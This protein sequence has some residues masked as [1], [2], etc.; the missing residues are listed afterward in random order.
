M[1]SIGMD[2]IPVKAA[3]PLIASGLQSVG[4]VICLV[5]VT[6][7]AKHL[8]YFAGKAFATNSTDLEQEIVERITAFK[9]GGIS[10][11]AFAEFLLGLSNQDISPEIEQQILAALGKSDDQIENT[12]AESIH[13]RNT[14]IA[15]NNIGNTDIESVRIENSHSANVDVLDSILSAVEKV[16]K[17][18]RD[19]VDREKPFQDYGLDS[20]MATQFAVTLEQA[21]E[22]NIPPGW[23]I[24]FATINALTKQIEHT[25][26][27]HN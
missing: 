3:L 19:K 11:D 27:Q 4:D 24:E 22:L 6:D 9:A 15:S 14:N 17:L 10:Q 26:S 7:K 1:K 13:T 8:R 23:F 21:F 12:N 20:I 16:F 25:L 5:A 18:E 2:A